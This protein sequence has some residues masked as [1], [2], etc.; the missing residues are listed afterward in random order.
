MQSTYILQ[1]TKPRGYSYDSTTRGTLTEYKEY[2]LTKWLLELSP[3]TAL[4][5][6]RLQEDMGFTEWKDLVAFVRAFLGAHTEFE[7]LAHSGLVIGH[8]A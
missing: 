4:K 6:E 1:S 7:L 5:L 2:H 8:D 3:G